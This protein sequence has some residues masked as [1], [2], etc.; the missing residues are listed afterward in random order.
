M[1]S[2]ICCTVC[3]RTSLPQ[4]G[5]VRLADRGKEQPQV[6][7]DLRHRADRRARVLRDRL[8]LDRD[9][10]RQPVD[11]VDVRLLHL[12]EKLPRVG[13]ERLDV[14]PLPLGVQ[15]VEGE[16]RLAR[17]R[18]PRHHDQLVAGNLDRDVLEIVLARAANDD[19]IHSRRVYGTRQ[20][21]RRPPRRRSSAPPTRARSTRSGLPGCAPTQPSSEF[22][23]SCCASQRLF[24]RVSL[25]GVGTS[26][27]R[28]RLRCALL[29]RIMREVSNMPAPML[30]PPPLTK[31][32]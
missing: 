31:G 24:N 21:R 8:L 16:R 32:A 5:T 20:G 17:A 9:R 26:R 10:R 28:R 19:R 23:A 1:R 15:R 4:V 27:I 29:V 11:R 13:R 25:R 14:A 30:P 22:S 12:L 3:G 2:T 18:D 6:V 7:V